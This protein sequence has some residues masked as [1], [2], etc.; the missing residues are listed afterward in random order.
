[1]CGND[2]RAIRGAPREQRQAAFDALS[3]ALAR[4]GIEAAGFTSVA[5]FLAEA[6]SR[7]LIVSME[8]LLE[9]TDQVNLPGTTDS[10]LNWQRR[11]PVSLES[12]NAHSGLLSAA[13]A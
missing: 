4:R 7:L 9:T 12:L 5:R 13:E 2:F 10:H 3:T 11:L 8:D 1:L 6:P